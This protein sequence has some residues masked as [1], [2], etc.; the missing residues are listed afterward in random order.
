MRLITSFVA[1]MACSL[2]LEAQIGFRLDL[3]EENQT[4]EGFGTSI[5]GS[6]SLILENLGNPSL[7]N[8]YSKELGASLFFLELRPEVSTFELR[9]W[10]DL[11]YFDHDLSLAR[12][13]REVIS[14]ASNLARLPGDPVRIVATVKS[15]PAWMKINDSIGN[16]D[17]DGGSYRFDLGTTLNPYA[18]PEEL[19][20][21]GGMRLVYTNANALERSRYRHFA[22]YLSEWT[23]Q[24]EE[25]G[26]EIFALC[27]QEDPVH[28]TAGRSA[29]YSPELYKDLL[30]GI[31]ELYTEIG[32]E[33]PRL[34][35]PGFETSDLGAAVEYLEFLFGEPRAWEF[36]WRVTSKGMVDGARESTDPFAPSA[37]WDIVR[38]FDKTYWVTGGASG[39]H[40]WPGALEGIAMMHHNALAEGNASAIVFSELSD[41]SNGV[42]GLL[43]GTALSKKSYAAMHYWRHARPGS[44]RVGLEPDDSEGP[45]RATAFHHREEG[46]LSLVMINRSDEEQEVE[47]DMGAEAPAFGEFQLVVTD[48]RRN[49]EETARIRVEPVIEMVP[50]D[51]LGTEEALYDRHSSRSRL[52]LAPVNEEDEPVV[53]V[54]D[55]DAPSIDM[56]GP[57]ASEQPGPPR[58]PKTADTDGEQADDYVDLAR[59]E[60]AAAEAAGRN[61]DFE[62]G[63]ENVAANDDQ[64]ELE[65]DE[66][67]LVDVAVDVE[68]TKEAD[69][70]VDLETE[71]T[72]EVNEEEVLTGTELELEADVVVED[73]EPMVEVEPEPEPEPEPV[74][75]PVTR[76][77]VLRLA[78]PA[79]SVVTAYSVE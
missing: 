21:Q 25:E 57:V 46:R 62:D 4:I 14:F 39:P 12:G 74:M 47:I 49:F 67:D 29:V 59:E 75:I 7:A 52:L 23:R 18:T 37:F 24:L 16:E 17:P 50:E 76:G 9:F 70:V 11:S 40:D 65:Q 61:P 71:V 58:P 10:R 77:Y 20:E 79:E 1:V 22:K 66:G 15:P 32:L 3:E 44:V 54:E 55:E 30:I 68:A 19:E 27:P 72:V 28:S 73:E 78:L 31:V 51:S 26:I 34:I 53:V 43:R 63:E 56:M 45:V 2:A 69:E 35:G 6:S 8:T 41:S 64:T 36:L 33:A 60:A 13:A 38:V 48:G 5:D 42:S